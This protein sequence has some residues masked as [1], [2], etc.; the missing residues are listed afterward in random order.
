VYKRQVEDGTR[1]EFIN[2]SFFADNLNAIE[3]FF[4]LENTFSQDIEVEITFLNDLEEERYVINF[5]AAR[6][7]D[8]AAQLTTF[9]DVV[10]PEELQNLTQST[11]LRYRL[12]VQDDG[13]P[14]NGTLN[15]RSST[16]FVLAIGGPST[17]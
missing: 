14:V 8:G 3:F 17:N 1:L 9:L 2:S 6:S 5:I 11:Q 15:F 16:N 13:N 4:R 10:P 12:A 7:N